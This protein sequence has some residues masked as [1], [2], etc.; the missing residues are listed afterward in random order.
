MLCKLAYVIYQ[1][2]RLH[3]KRVA[4]TRLEEITTIRTKDM[5]GLTDWSSHFCGFSDFHF[6]HLHFRDGKSCQHYNNYYFWFKIHQK[7]S[8]KKTISV[9]KSSGC[10]ISSHEFVFSLWTANL[11]SQLEFDSC[12]PRPS[13]TSA[14]GV[15]LSVILF[16]GL[17]KLIL[18][19]PGH[20]V[21]EPWGCF[22]VFF[23]KQKTFEA[24][25]D[26]FPAMGTMPSRK[27]V[28][29]LHHRTW[30]FFRAPHLRTHFLGIL[31]DFSRTALEA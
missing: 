13:R 27:K 9:F 6:F 2:S 28:H 11:L 29:K 16:L 24:F 23:P 20:P 30:V 1:L 22:F 25:E 10:D 8:T 4:I 5:D 21:D 12:K 19:I 15:W 7:I 18:M 17:K 26:I 3:S 14:V 31:V